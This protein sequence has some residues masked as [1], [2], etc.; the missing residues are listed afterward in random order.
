[1]MDKRVEYYYF[2]INTLKWPFYNFT[3]DKDKDGSAMK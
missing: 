1:M 3:K 2:L